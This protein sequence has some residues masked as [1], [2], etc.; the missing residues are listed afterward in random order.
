MSAGFRKSL[1]GFNCDDVLRY[2]ESAQMRYSQNEAEYKSKISQIEGQLSAA[3]ESIEAISSERD[4]LLAELTEFRRKC[5]EIEQLSA[6]IGK[7][8]IV[9]QNS[10]QNIISNSVESSRIASE[11]VNKNIDSIDAAHTALAD[12]RTSLEETT[13]DFITRISAL[14]ASL[15]A[16]KT[17]LEERSGESQR[18]YE[19]FNAIFN[20]INNAQ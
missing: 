6:S 18:H 4:S 12:I 11:E 9:S 17:D 3:L 19:E 2:I 13:A 8:Y 10:A 16:A 1:F 15:D 5:D 14:C 20:K 7:L